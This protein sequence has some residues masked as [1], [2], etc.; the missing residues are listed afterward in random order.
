MR[1][2]GRIHEYG[3]T[4]KLTMI[5]LTSD[6]DRALTKNFVEMVLSLSPDI[7]LILVEDSGKD[8]SFAK[9]WNVGI[10]RFLEKPTEYLMF[11][12]DDAKINEDSF[13]RLFSC[14]ESN[15]GLDG[16]VPIVK[17][18]GRENLSAFER[19]IPGE[20]YLYIRIGSVIPISIFP[21]IEP[22]R[23]FVRI[24][25]FPPRAHEENSSA[26]ETISEGDII[27]LF[28]LVLLRRDMIVSVG[29]FDES[30]F[31]GEDLDFTFRLYLANAKIGVVRS[32]VVEHIGS[33]SIGKRETKR[34]REKYAHLKKELVAYNKVYKKFRK[35]L[36]EV[37]LSAR[38]NTILI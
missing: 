28:P 2:N 7:R 32:S 21:L 31:F 5:A 17:E 26:S 14:I 36:H 22:F 37:R 38:N 1:F 6:K 25:L 29:L 16:V 18:P 20:S 34:P 30:F 27:R 23:N 4:D 33:Y 11:A 10:T 3:S 13:L 8:F 12:H 9:S 15:K 19:M 24:K 35:R